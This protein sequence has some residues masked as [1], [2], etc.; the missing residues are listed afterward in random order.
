MPKK[1]DTAGLKHFKGKENAMIA[2]KP[3]STNTA[4]VAHAVGEYFYWKGVLHIVTAAIAVGGTI[5]TNTN[6]KPAVLADDVGA[7]KTALN[8]IYYLK[9]TIV[10]GA[11]IDSTTGAV[12]LA[13]AWGYI[14]YNVEGLSGNTVVYSTKLYNGHSVGLAC[15][16]T[17]GSYISGTNVAI[18]TLTIP[19]NCAVINVSYFKQNFTA[20]DVV[21]NV[22][23][24]NQLAKKT[25]QNDVVVN[26]E[27]IDGKII[28]DADNFEIGDISISTTGWTYSSTT[29]RVRTK[30]GVTYSLKR[31]DV[32]SLT[33]YTNS[34]FYL[35]WK[36]NNN[37]YGL[38]GWNLADYTIQEDGEYV[39][40]L[41]PRNTNALN[42][43]YGLISKLIITRGDYAV[44]SFK[45]DISSISTD[46]INSVNHR[47][48]NT[49][50]P[51]NT[52][53]AFVLSRKNG[54]SYVETD[55]QFTSDG[56][57]VCLHD[58]SINRTA[59]NADGTAI[60][61][62]VNIA[63]ITYEQALTYDFGIY[64]GS[65]Y[66]GTKIPTLSQ[67][68]TFIRNSGIKCYIEIKNDATYTEEQ[69]KSIVD[70]TIAHGVYDRCTFISFSLTYLDYIKTYKSDA[71]LGYVRN[72]ISSAST[73]AEALTLKTASNYVFI[74][75]NYSNLTSENVTSCISS[76]IPLEVYTVND[77]AS[78]I[79]LNPYITGVTSDSIVA[80]KVLYDNAMN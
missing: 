24:S 8:S 35:G 10:D 13:G 50:A 78:I 42:S 60:S 32:V 64:K 45:N 4:T 63:D 53:P 20:N 12:S 18:G 28:I 27:A 33:S 57:A 21:F 37:T 54:F 7:L 16:A 48:F 41:D 3:E 11:Y 47:G 70:E 62:T 43:I 34:R 76:G 74:D 9:K 79:A 44:N 59:R 66:A 68:L 36:R 38:A 23:L 49:V 80:S 61:G 29:Y 30:Q 31:G 1:I 67:F 73:L 26:V 65:Y 15:I 58:T 75:V 39:I 69:V 2:G 46:I 19:Q 77:K 25:I 6:V 14:S 51:E 5:Q 56:V 40:L 22:N 55:V 17:D 52:I 71:R 72:G